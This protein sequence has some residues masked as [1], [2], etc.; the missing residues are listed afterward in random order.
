M[1]V[2]ADDISKT[3]AATITKLDMQMFD[4]E[5]WKF[6]YFGVKRSKVKVATSVSVFRLNAILPLVEI[7]LLTACP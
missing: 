1:A 4:D 6:I 5:S 3:D 7:S 2:F